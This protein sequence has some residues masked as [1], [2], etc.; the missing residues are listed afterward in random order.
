MHSQS[1]HLGHQSQS[2]YNGPR[3]PSA[4][5]PTLAQSLFSRGRR[6]AIPTSSTWGSLAPLGVVRAACKC[7]PPFLQQPRSLTT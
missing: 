4:A 2:P 7:L 3:E 1:S 6:L 5:L